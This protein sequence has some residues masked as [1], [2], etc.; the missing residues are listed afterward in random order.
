VP[1]EWANVEE[2]VCQEEEESW[3][4][5]VIDKF[6]EFLEAEPELRA[7][8]GCVCAGVNESKEIA[9]RLGMEE[10]AVV[11]GRK[12]LARRAG[13]FRRGLKTKGANRLSPWRG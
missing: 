4:E 8:F 3:R 12:K 6:E 2:S 13:E 11:K 5:R 1:A 7:I 9:R 10:A